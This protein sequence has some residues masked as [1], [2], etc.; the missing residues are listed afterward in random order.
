MTTEMLVQDIETAPAT[1]LVGRLAIAL[2]E[3]NEV[4]IKAISNA[5]RDRGDRVETMLAV[6]ALRANMA[7]QG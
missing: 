7:H 6:A 2:Q 3:G 4:A 1:N 5:I